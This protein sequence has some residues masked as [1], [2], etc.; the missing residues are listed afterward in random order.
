VEAAVAVEAAVVEAA[1]AA[2]LGHIVALLIRVFDGAG[3]AKVVALIAVGENSAFLHAVDVVD[4]A[5]YFLEVY[6]ERDTV[7]QVCNSSD[8]D[9]T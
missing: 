3:V 8:L 7:A 6:P 5:E 2:G 9:R 4:T 1:A